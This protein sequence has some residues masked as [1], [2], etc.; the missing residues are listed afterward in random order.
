MKKLWIVVS[1]FT[2]LALLAG[3]APAA[4]PTPVVVEKVKTVVVKETEIVE[5]LI[6]PTPAFKPLRFAYLPNLADHPAIMKFIEGFKAESEHLGATVEVFDA[7]FDAN[8][9][10]SLIEETIAAGFDGFAY[11]PVDASACGPALEKAHK[12]GLKIVVVGN[13]AAPEIMPFID[14]F[15]GADMWAQGRMA[16]ENV[17]DAFGDKPLKVVII[18]GMVGTTAAQGRTEGFEEKL[19]ELCPQAEIIG[20]QPADWDRAKALEIMENFLT[21]FPEIDVVY[22]NDD[23]MAFGAIQAIKAA[24]RMDEITAFGV[25]AMCESVEPIKAGELWGTV[26]QSPSL[27][28]FYAARALFDLCNGRAVPDEMLIPLPKLTKDN[29]DEWQCEY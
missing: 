12:A 4:T 8:L 19:A 17:Y 6:T 26:V 28:N 9:Q 14:C 25:D 24:G 29:I 16:A 10:A 2:I 22:A 20:K 11:I 21:R 1:A 15:A 7:R 13:P 23:N 5:K 3:C 27:M 18:T